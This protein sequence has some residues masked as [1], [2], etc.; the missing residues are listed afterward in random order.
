MVPTADE[1]VEAQ[2]E[3]RSPSQVV[4]DPGALHNPPRPPPQSS[5]QAPSGSRAPLSAG[6]I[7][8][9]HNTHGSTW[10][11]TSIPGGSVAKWL[12]HRAWV[13]APAL[14]LLHR[15]TSGD[16]QNRP[17]G[18]VGRMKCAHSW[19]QCL[20]QGLT[21]VRAKEVSAIILSQPHPLPQFTFAHKSQEA[22]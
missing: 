19:L 22:S 8:S 6:Q 20:E 2:E 14:W 10:N 21:Q 17:H 18:G 7:P 15:V 16:S 3:P 1:E 13:P 9:K 5:G 4:G 11:T 12:E